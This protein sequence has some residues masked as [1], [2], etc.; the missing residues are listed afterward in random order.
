MDGRRTLDIER[1]EAVLQRLRRSQ[2]PCVRLRRQHSRVHRSART[3][4]ASGRADA[5]ATASSCCCPTQDLL[6]VLSEE[7]ELALVSATADKFNGAR[8]VP[9]DRRQ[10]LEPPG[11]GWRRPPGSKRRGDGGVPAV[12]RQP[13]N[14]GC[15]KATT[16]AETAEPPR[17]LNSTLSDR[18][19]PAGYLLLPRPAS[20][21]LTIER[22]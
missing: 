12:P 16:N 10:D 19:F 17:I 8:A 13:L 14:K 18:R 7:G 1:A 5:T 20:T 4:S 6:L 11:A 2:R 21:A 3:A 22:T 9:G 15:W